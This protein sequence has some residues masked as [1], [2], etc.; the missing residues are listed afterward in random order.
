MC[1]SVIFFRLT[2]DVKIDCVR[3]DNKQFTV[4][5]SVH[6]LSNCF[7]FLFVNK[8]ERTRESESRK[9]ERQREREIQKEKIETER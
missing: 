8:L 9:E 3:F 1:L 5:N 2:H 4:R 6:M 7:H